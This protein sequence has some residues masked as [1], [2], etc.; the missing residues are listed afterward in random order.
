MGPLPHLPLCLTY[1]HNYTTSL[2]GSSSSSRR[3]QKHEAQKPGTA[4]LRMGQEVGGSRLGRKREPVAESLR[5][6]FVSRLLARDTEM[7][8][9]KSDRPL[10]ASYQS[11]IFQ[12]KLDSPGVH[13]LDQQTNGSPLISRAAPHLPLCPPLASATPPAASSPLQR[14]TIPSLQWLVVT[15]NY[16]RRTRKG[17]PPPLLRNSEN[18]S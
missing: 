3:E 18:H 15:R 8:A 11:R 7:S 13:G 1:E 10:R 9:N 12:G 14:L 5:F 6:C 2:K 4:A 17:K 16:G